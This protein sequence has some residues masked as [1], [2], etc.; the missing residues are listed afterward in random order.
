MSQ[1]ARGW[2]YRSSAPVVLTFFFKVCVH[3][4]SFRLVCLARLNFS[5]AFP[6]AQ[7]NK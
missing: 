2:S 4:L 7:V 1:P 3:I 6:T 5:G